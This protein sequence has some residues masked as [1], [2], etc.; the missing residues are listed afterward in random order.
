M[1]AIGPDT[2]R[3]SNGSDDGAFGTTPGE[4]RKPTT[5]LKFA[6]L[7]SE[8]PMSPPSASGSRLAASAAP[9]PPLEPP[10]LFSRFHGLRVVPYTVL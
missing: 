2:E 5:L 7:R 6:G 10:A 8:P 3:F 9:A 4:G 1:R